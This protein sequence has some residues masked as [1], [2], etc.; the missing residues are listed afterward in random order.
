MSLVAFLA[1]LKNKYGIDALTLGMSNTVTARVKEQ[2][3]PPPPPKMPDPD[4]PEDIDHVTHKNPELMLMDAA[5]E[6]AWFA[7]KRPPEM[8]AI[9]EALLKGLYDG[10]VVIMSLFLEKMLIVKI[11]LNLSLGWVTSMS[12]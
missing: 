11:F 7:S 1:D 9:H 5:R 10:C 3:P 2:D 12:K 4:D 8:D 6:I